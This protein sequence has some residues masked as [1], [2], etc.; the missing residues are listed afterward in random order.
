L[1]AGIG[2]LRG[3]LPDT[4]HMASSDNALHLLTLYPS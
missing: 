4:Q 2:F 1:P 3:G